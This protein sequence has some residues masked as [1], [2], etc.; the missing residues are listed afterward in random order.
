MEHAQP[1]LFSHRHHS[2]DLGI[3]CRYCHTTAEK[4]AFAGM[5][6]TATCLNCHRGLFRSSEMLA[7]LWESLEE[8]TPLAW[9]RVHDLK[10]VVFFNHQVHV[11]AGISCRDCHGNVEEMVTARQ[12][13]PMT[14]Q[15]CLECH[16]NP[17]ETIRRTDSP[18]NV[19][20]AAAP[21]PASLIPALQDAHSPSAT[22]APP[23]PH[24]EP[25]K[26]A[27]LADCS[28]CHR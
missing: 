24:R 26:T 5:P 8:G 21:R 1:I 11:S 22:T 27:N 15:W 6:S 17:N 4:S 10:D 16:R 2:G 7:P 19:R 3:D 12:Q 25:F 14:M 13:Q 28:A 20:R 18:I 23:N 9:S